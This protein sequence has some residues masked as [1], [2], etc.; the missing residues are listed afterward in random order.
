[1]GCALTGG[2]GRGINRPWRSVPI[3]GKS[4]RW[5]CRQRIGNREGVR[6]SRA[7]ESRTEV[8]ARQRSRSL[9]QTE[10]PHPAVHRRHIDSD[11][12]PV[13][14]SECS[15]RRAQLRDLPDLC[16]LLGLLGGHAQR[17]Q[18]A[19]DGKQHRTCGNVFGVI[20]SDWDLPDSN[21]TVE[22]VLAGVRRRKLSSNGPRQ[23]AV[24]GS[25]RNAC[26][27]RNRVDGGRPAGRLR[28]GLSVRGES[29][30]ASQRP[31]YATE[32]RRAGLHISVGHNPR[33]TV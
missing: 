18:L 22:A 11:A 3:M 33:V 23:L 20:G 32:P 6:A 4:D 17:Y 10:R 5:A 9:A 16:G 1:M 30:Q 26:S 12:G 28:S 15:G 14:P 29:R 21:R 19:F 25:R 31:A 24:I 7:R 8:S 27:A 13:R 2:L